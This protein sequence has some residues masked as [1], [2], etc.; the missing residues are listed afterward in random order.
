MASCPFVTA[1]D[2]GLRPNTICSFIEYCTEST[3]LIDKAIL[4]K[5]AVV[6]GA[7]RGGGFGVPSEL[8][9]QRNV[10]GLRLLGNARDIDQHGEDGG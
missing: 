8:K 10:G 2:S 1:H 6:C 3:R 4:D 9:G 5:M 7:R